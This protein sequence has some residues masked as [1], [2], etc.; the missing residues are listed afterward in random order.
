[1]QPNKYSKKLQA[2][3]RRKF[4]L[5]RG[6]QLAVPASV[7]GVILSVFLSG[8]TEDLLRIFIFFLLIAM[9]TAAIISVDRIFTSYD[10]KRIP[11]GLLQ[12]SK[13]VMHT[14]AMLIVFIAFYYLKDR[15]WITTREQAHVFLPLLVYA[16]IIGF[17]F[18]LV[19]LISRMVGYGVIVK[20]ISGKYH[21]PRETDRIF[22][23]LDLA[24]S[25]TLAEKLGHKSYFSLINDVLFDITPCIHLNGGEIYKYVGDE[26]IIT[27]PVNKGLRQHNC[28]RVY[29][30]VEQKI[31]ANRNKYLK[32]Y[33]VIPRFKAG[34]HMGKVIIGEMGDYKSEIAYMGDAV[35]ISA[36]LQAMCRTYNAGLLISDTLLEKLPR[37]FFFHYQKL[38]SVQLKGKLQP[39]IPARIF[40]SEH[41]DA[42]PGATQPL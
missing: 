14:L 10:F 1:M 42:T 3:E 41:A 25:T 27:W 12:L 32:K 29:F 39:T 4:L 36:R 8:A 24:D 11:F 30:D 16:W 34:A 28:I 13:L 7:G 9:I 17:I 40:L 22:M 20:Y 37:P 21:R 2:R 26:I 23:F 18:T 35:N 5:K 15:T 19:F 6:L 31:D 38:K 33:G